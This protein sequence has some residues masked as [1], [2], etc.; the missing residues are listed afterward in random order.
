MGGQYLTPLSETSAEGYDPR[1]HD[2]GFRP[3]DA[4]NHYYEAEDAFTRHIDPGMAKR[5]M[6]WAEINGRRRL[7]VGGR[8]NKFIPNPTFDPI[9]KPGSLEDYFR[10]RNED[11]IDLKTMF[12]DLE[13]IADH[14]GYRERDARLALLDEQGM[15]GALLFPT[16]GVGM[17][18][19]LKHDLPALQAAFSAF[20]RWLDDDWGFDRGD[21]RLYAAPMV[22]LAE[23]DLAVA[24]VERVLGAGARILVMIPGPVPDGE[25]F[26]SPGHPKFDPVWARINEAGI[27]LAIHAGL[28]GVSQYGKLWGTGAERGGGGFEGFKHASFPLVAFQD[29]GISDTFAALICHGV[30]ERFPNLRLASIENGAMWVPDLLRNL[31]DARGKMPFSFQEH[32]VEQF[33]RRVWVAP[34][35]EDDMAMLKDVVGIERLLFGSDFPH[36]EGLPEPTHFVKDIPTFTDDETRAIMRDN[37]LEL[38]TPQP[39]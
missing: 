26:V 35:Y 38:L 13:P 29:R 30:L 15:E 28:S 20:N 37:V 31:K 2:L 39:A 1:M 10:G 27:P 12:G 25:G 22:T 19:A 14:P 18:E 9:A 4:D 6:Q 5:C 36:T 32:P 23:P 8:V 17:Q 24:E 11:G 21:G 16:L 33:T 7:L 34:Y 3:F